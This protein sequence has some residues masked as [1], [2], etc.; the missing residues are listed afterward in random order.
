MD[1]SDVK[2]KSFLTKTR[3]VAY[4]EKAVAISDRWRYEIRRHLS[5]LDFVL[6][7]T[8]TVN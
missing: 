4:H 2:K 1:Q 6:L 5:T 8:Y 3:I 7:T